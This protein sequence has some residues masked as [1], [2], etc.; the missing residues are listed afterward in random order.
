MD[1][2]TVMTPE[3]LSLALL[4]LAGPAI[5]SHS[6]ANSDAY[7]PSKANNPFYVATPTNQLIRNT[8]MQSSKEMPI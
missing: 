1:S 3:V 5:R 7:A 2:S 8:G 6:S 4:L